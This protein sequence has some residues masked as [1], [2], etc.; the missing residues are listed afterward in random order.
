MRLEEHQAKAIEDLA[1]AI[2]IPKAAHRAESPTWGPRNTAGRI[3]GDAG[4]LTKAAN[5]DLDVMIDNIGKYDKRCAKSYRKAAEK[6]KE[7]IRKN[8]HYFDD[9]LNDILDSF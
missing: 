7:K 4:D 5:R 1:D 9:F 2:A 3:K 8:D 6:L